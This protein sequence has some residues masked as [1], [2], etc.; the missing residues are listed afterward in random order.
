MKL[1]VINV[2]SEERRVILLFDPN[3]PTYDDES[4]QEYLRANN[5]EPKRSY[6]ELRNDKDYL[7]Y[8]YGHCYLEDHLGFLTDR[9]IES[10]T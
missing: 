10:N 1:E 4:I 3:N 5:L 2:T 7:V 6:H 8:Y 9:S